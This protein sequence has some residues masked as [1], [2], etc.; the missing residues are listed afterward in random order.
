MWDGICAFAKP[1][2]HKCGPDC[3]IAHGS[4]QIGEGIFVIFRLPEDAWTGR[5]IKFYPA[6]KGAKGALVQALSWA[7][8]SWVAIGPRGWAETAKHHGHAG[9]RDG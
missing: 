7:C 4:S 9:E 3:A 2:L 8:A 6:I 1:I 5:E